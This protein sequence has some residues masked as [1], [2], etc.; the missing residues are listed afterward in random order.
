MNSTPELLHNVNRIFAVFFS[1]DCLERRKKVQQWCHQ[2]DAKSGAANGETA[3]IGPTMSLQ[4]VSD[5]ISIRH[6]EPQTTWGPLKKTAG[7]AKRNEMSFPLAAQVVVSLT[8]KLLIHT[9]LQRGV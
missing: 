3:Y 4:N 5:A 6:F 9:A 1:D 2:L 8:D 7:K